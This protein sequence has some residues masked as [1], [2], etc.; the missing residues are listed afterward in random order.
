MITYHHCY[1]SDSEFNKAENKLRHH[2]SEKKLNLGLL[3]GDIIDVGNPRGS[4]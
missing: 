3:A 1:S 2:R 4:I